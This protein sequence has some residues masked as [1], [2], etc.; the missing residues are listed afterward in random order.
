MGKVEI[1]V[2]N[3]EITVVSRMGAIEITVGHV[4]ITGVFNVGIEDFSLW[5]R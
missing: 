3:I 2:D 5:L 1:K 4:M